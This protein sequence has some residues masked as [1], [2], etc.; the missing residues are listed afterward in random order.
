MQKF[1]Q[2]L[3]SPF[4]LLRWQWA[5]S[6][7]YWLVV[8]WHCQFRSTLLGRKINDLGVNCVIR[9]FFRMKVTLRCKNLMRKYFL[10]HK[11]FFKKLTIFIDNALLSLPFS[12]LSHTLLQNVFPKILVYRAFMQS[13]HFF[14]R[15]NVSN[16]LTHTQVRAFSFFFMKFSRFHFSEH[17]IITLHLA[18]LWSCCCCDE[19]EPN[20]FEDYRD[21]CGFDIKIN[22]VVISFSTF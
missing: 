16:T 19:N 6:L 12:H 3:S 5:Y 15:Q 1:Y 17:F 22:K 8:K 7:I 2:I 14:I 9:N 10:R 21:K 4:F 20:A 11:I 13:S 18:G